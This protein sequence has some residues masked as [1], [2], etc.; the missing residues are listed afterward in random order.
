MYYYCWSFWYNFSGEI[1]YAKLK[2][3]KLAA[4]SDLASVEQ[5]VTENNNNNNNNNN[6]KSNYKHM[7]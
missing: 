3:A 1:L 7:T 4:N 5:R 2:K 6:K